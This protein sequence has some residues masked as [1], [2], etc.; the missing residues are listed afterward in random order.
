MLPFYCS[1]IPF[2]IFIMALHFSHEIYHLHLKFFLES[3]HMPK[4]CLNALNSLHMPKPLETPYCTHL[5][6]SYKHS[7][8][9]HFLIPHLIH[10]CFCTH[11]P[12]TPHLHYIQFSFWFS[13][14]S[15]YSP[16]TTLLIILLHHIIFLCIHFK[17]PI[18]KHSFNS[19]TTTFLFH[20]F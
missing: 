8:P 19:S 17:W 6:R 20:L 2:M 15:I 10:M 11:T 1:S 14:I 5:A 7:S 16:N 4:P 12:H 18:F 9:L 13:C 3:L